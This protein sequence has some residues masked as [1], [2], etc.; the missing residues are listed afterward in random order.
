MRLPSQKLLTTLHL[1]RKNKEG[2]PRH[3]RYPGR[4]PLLDG[5][6]QKL[7]SAR[8]GQI[9]RE[10]CWSKRQRCVGT[11]LRSQRIGRRLAQ[12]YCSAA[13]IGRALGRGQ[14]GSRIDP[15]D[16]L[17]KGRAI[18]RAR[19]IVAAAP[20]TRGTLGEGAYERM[21]EHSSPLLRVSSDVAVPGRALAS[22]RYSP[23]PGTRQ[24]NQDGHCA[25]AP[26]CC[27]AVL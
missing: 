11:G 13:A 20:L 15:F 4:Y 22:V 14:S 17:G 5:L 1:R 26:C 19:G 18:R 27:G 6:R 7:T 25:R 21:P 23:H 24:Q 12:K 3:R 10:L 16:A 8:P 9:D 2:R